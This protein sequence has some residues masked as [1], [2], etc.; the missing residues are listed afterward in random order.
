MELDGQTPFKT[1]ALAASEQS[2]KTKLRKARMQPM[3]RC[4]AHPA[5]KDLVL[6][7]I[8]NFLVSS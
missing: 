7:L 6:K 5:L 4:E 2:V 3:F 1:A 8:H